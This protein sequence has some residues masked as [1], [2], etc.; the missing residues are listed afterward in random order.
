ME[1][2]SKSLVVMLSCVVGGYMLVTA[3][4]DPAVP[5]NDA[6][7]ASCSSC[8]PCSIGAAP[9]HTTDADAPFPNTMSGQACAKLESLGC[10]EAHPPT[11]EGCVGVL[12]KTLK[13]KVFSIDVQCILSAPNVQ[14]V[15]TCGV[16]CQT[17]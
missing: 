10:P 3:C 4:K 12:D 15:R 2:L 13:D 1:K 17:E 6:D 8:P 14:S 9:C 7:A 5:P 16:R 11:G